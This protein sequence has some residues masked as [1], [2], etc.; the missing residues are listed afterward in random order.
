KFLNKLIEKDPGGTTKIAEMLKPEN[1]AALDEYL[2]ARD[3]ARDYVDVL[4]EFSSIK[5]TPQEFVDSTRALAIRLYSIASSLR[6]HPEEVHLTVAT[7][8]YQSHGR[9]R[10]GLAST[11]LAERYEGDTTA[12]VFIQAQKHFRMPEDTSTPLIM[13]GP[14]TGLAPFRAF[15]EER[16][17]IGAKGKNWLFFGEQRSASDFF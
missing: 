12:G 11:F 7:V 14:G 15:L 10:E 2:I 6:A 5:F 3:G 1:K 8:R 13:V 17:V 9:K 4:R 16:E